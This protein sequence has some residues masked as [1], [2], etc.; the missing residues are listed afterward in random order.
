MEGDDQALSIFRRAE[1]RMCDVESRSRG[2]TS[3]S[4]VLYG[5]PSFGTVRAGTSC[6]C[7]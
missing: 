2:A 4:A 5:S 7:A 6:E 3:R 1:V